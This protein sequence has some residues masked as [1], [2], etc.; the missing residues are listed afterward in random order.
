M[1]ETQPEGRVWVFQC[2][3]KT[4]FRGTALF[5]AREVQSFWS[6][7][8]TLPPHSVEC[9]GREYLAAITNPR[10]Q[11]NLGFGAGG[12]TPCHPVPRELTE[13]PESLCRSSTPAPTRTNSRI[14][15]GASLH[16]SSACVSPST[17][18]V[19]V[20][21]SNKQPGR[22]V[23][24][25]EFLR[26][27]LAMMPSA[28]LPMLICQQRAAA[29]SATLSHHRAFINCRASSSVITRPSASY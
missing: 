23:V 8:V 22:L 13:L 5:L 25:V 2:H 18:G 28:G 17:V 26:S 24:E 11:G 12:G 10:Y 9:N 3:G 27:R 20:E 14:S 29:E 7:L 16:R 6:T 4:T 21:V 19:K 1:Q 15:R